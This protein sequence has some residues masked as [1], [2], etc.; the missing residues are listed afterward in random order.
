MHLWIERSPRLNRV[1]KEEIPRT[2]RKREYSLEALSL[3]LLLF[4][5]TP[6][7]RH[8][9][10]RQK[11]SKDL[12]TGRRNPTVVNIVN[13][14]RQWITYKEQETLNTFTIGR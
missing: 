12:D 11:S 7:E 2:H 8:V 5:M 10:D 4:I 1:R 9:L 6:L 3:R 13:I 14:C